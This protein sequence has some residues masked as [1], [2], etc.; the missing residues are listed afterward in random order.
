MKINFKD[1]F[2]CLIITILSLFK[3]F[4]FETLKCSKT[5]IFFQT[6][7]LQKD[8]SPQYPGGKASMYRFISKNVAYPA[9]AQKANIQGKVVVKFLIDKDGKISKASI[10]KGIGNGC[11]EEAIRIINAMPAW[12]PASRNGQP[13]ASY[14]TLPIVFKLT[15]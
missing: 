12:I 1:L 4:A 15:K 8:V 14:Y 3:A 13:I 11:D 10:I 5:D 2:I 7:S 6:D 9:V